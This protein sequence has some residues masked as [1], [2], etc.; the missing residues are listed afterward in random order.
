MKPLQLAAWTTIAVLMLPGLANAQRT[1]EPPAPAAAAAMEPAVVVG[2]GD[3]ANCEVGD[4]H[5]ATGRLLDDIPGTVITLGD[6]AYPKGSR[7]SFE[8]CYGRSWG[9][10]KARTRPSPGNHDYMTNNG[11][12]YYDYFGDNAGPRKRGYYSYQLGA[13]HIVSLNSDAPASR[14]S[15]QIEW[16]RKDL[17]VHPTACTL[18]YWHVPVF[19]SGA[20]GND[21]HMVEAWRVLHEFGADVVLNGHDHSYERFALQDP[22]GRADPEHGIRAFVVGT[23]GGGVYPFADQK[24]NSEVR[25]HTSYGVIKLTLY[26]DRYDW[27]F[28][29][30]KGQPFSDKGSAACVQA[31][32]PAPAAIA[33]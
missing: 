8:E 25:H 28:I 31:A 18:A 30:A 12:P 16:L 32:T 13:W 9:R 19:S 27:E 33:H 15:K 3:I 22:D 10:H 2:A 23:G 29:T 6:H 11:I 14:A 21:R 5:E 7:K 4:G 17:A 1:A 26:A 24:P 20:H